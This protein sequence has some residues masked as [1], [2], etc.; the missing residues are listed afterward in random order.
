MM[1]SPEVFSTRNIIMELLAVSF[2]GFNSCSS[3]M[4][5]SPIGVAALSSPNMFAAIF[6]KIDPV[7][8]CPLGIS[9]K[10]LQNKGLSHLESWL[11]SPLSSPTFMIPIHKANT[12]VRPIDMSN[13]VWD[14][15][16]VESIIC[17]KTVVSPKKINLISAI[18][19]AIKKKA[20]QI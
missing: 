6:I 20:I 10:S 3:S 16:K 12:P 18:I 15:L 5:F 19:N 7:T 13:A 11:I 1:T 17:E 14:E 9:G 4:A 8:G 2:L